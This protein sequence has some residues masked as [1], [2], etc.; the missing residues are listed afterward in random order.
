MTRTRD[1]NG[2]KYRKLSWRE[3]FKGRFKYK[4]ELVERY[5]K[6][7]L[8]KMP[9]GSGERAIGPGGYVELHNLPNPREC[10]MV[11]NPGYQ[12]DGCSGPTIDR[13][14]NIRA[15]FLHDGGYQCSRE[16]LMDFSYV[17]VID[18]LFRAVLIEDGMWVWL[19]RRYFQAVNN[20]IIHNLCARPK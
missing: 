14:V 20:D 19:A 6:R 3:R 4:Y 17:G 13:T 8:V 16:R 2:L 11:L 1:A 9:P 5:S 7:I 18:K 12:C 10:L 15:G